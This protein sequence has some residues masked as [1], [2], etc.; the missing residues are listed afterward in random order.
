MILK[1]V[2]KEHIKYHIYSCKGAYNR[3]VNPNNKK[4][5]YTKISNKFIFFRRSTGYSSEVTKQRKHVE[6]SRKGKWRYASTNIRRKLPPPENRKWEKSLGIIAI[7]VTA[8]CPRLSWRS[9]IALIGLREL[10]ERPVI[11][12]AEIVVARRPGTYSYSSHLETVVCYQCCRG[13]TQEL[14]STN[15]S[16]WTVTFPRKM[17]GAA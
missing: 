2:T 8:T 15:T 3:G 1:K 17:N 9:T 4:V 5:K 11:G 14:P 7:S 13:T 10:I 6:S 12:G 16:S